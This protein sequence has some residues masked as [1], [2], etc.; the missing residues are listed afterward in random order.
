MMLGQRSRRADENPDGGWPVP[1]GE[2]IAR[3]AA[4]GTPGGCGASASPGVRG[5]MD[6]QGES[7]YTSSR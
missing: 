5:A 1:D 6:R 4:M 2:G 7:C 3:A